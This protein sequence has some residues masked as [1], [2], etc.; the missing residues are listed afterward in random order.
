MKRSELIDIILERVKEQIAD[1]PDTADSKV[2]ENSVLYGENG[3]V[4]SLGLVSIVLD[5]EQNLNDQL[6]SEIVIADE[7]AMSQKVSPFRTPGRLAD[8]VMSLINE[9]A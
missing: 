3:L 5:V 1:N 7:K 2:D 6:G 9:H 4:D 8:Y